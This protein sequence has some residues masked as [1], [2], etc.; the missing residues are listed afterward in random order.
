MVVDFGVGGCECSGVLILLSRVT[1]WFGG[2]GVLRRRYISFVVCVGYLC[3][4]YLGLWGCLMLFVFDLL[5]DVVLRLR[6]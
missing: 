2:L 4:C 6:V 5:D 1:L 3:L